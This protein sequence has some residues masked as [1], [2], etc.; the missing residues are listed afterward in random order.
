M[1][2]VRE[3][4][5]CLILKLNLCFLVLF[6]H[7]DRLRLYHALSVDSLSVKSVV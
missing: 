5:F 3:I 7:C 4:D 2:L 1:S 6:V